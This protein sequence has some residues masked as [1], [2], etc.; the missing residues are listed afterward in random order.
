MS[1]KSKVRHGL[2]LLM[3]FYLVCYAITFWSGKRGVGGGFAL[4][5]YLTLY[6]SA[7]VLSPFIGLHRQREQRA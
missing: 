5:D 4:F 6:P 1:Q 2:N 7:A 3:N